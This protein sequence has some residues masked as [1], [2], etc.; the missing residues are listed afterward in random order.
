MY[1]AVIFDVDGTLVDSNDAHARAWADA[2][3][4]SGRAME[5]TRVRPLIGMGSDKLLDAF[6][7]DSESEEG[8]RLGRRRREIFQQRYISTVKPTPGARELD[9]GLRDERMMLVVASSAERA[10]LHD[11]LR[12]AG[13]WRLF[14]DATSSDD[15]SRSKPDPDI[16]RAALARTGCGPQ[17]AVMI[18]DTP[19][20]IEAA[21]R[22]GIG[23]IA[24]RC[25][26]WWSDDALRN[27]IAIY[28]DPADLLDK[29]A[30]SPF[31]R[32]LPV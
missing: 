16:V 10:E 26:G 17:D 31:K 18:G 32:P 30:L 7:I 25:G 23:T 6:G 21:T 14:E 3:A 22:S 20:D 9:A 29:Y 24:L 28:D 5:Y 2:F 1:R 15:A 19:Y 8:Q 4:E 13:V 27:A 11:L 12:I